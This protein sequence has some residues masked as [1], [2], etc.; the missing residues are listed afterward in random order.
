MGH[1][2]RP[3]GSYVVPIKQSDASKSPDEVGRGTYVL[4]NGATYLYPVGGF[5]AP[6][7]AFHVQWDAAAIL[8]IAVEDCLFGDADA[9]D[10][11]VVKGDWMRE[12]GNGVAVSVTTSDGTTGGATVTNSVVTVAGGTAGGC[13]IQVPNNGSRRLRL[14]I[15]VGGT[16]GGVRVAESQKSF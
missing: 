16:G 13:M 10:I 8:T 12:I 5:D 9:A 11:S 2:R 14:R 15:D 7:L 4:A 6:W 3:G 1:N